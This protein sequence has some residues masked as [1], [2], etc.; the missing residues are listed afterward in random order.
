MVRKYAFRASFLAIDIVV[1]IVVVVSFNL[2]TNESSQLDP[3]IG[4]QPM[5][6][7]YKSKIETKSALGSAHFN[8]TLFQQFTLD[9]EALHLLQNSEN[10]VHHQTL[11]F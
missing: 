6:I 2:R 4:K 11:R 1:A 3:T 8:C 9:T 10:T 5:Q 7:F